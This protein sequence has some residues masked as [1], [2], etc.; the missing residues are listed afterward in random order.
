MTNKDLIALM[1]NPEVQVL[2]T[3]SFIP[4]ELAKLM[5]HFLEELQS[6]DHEATNY[7][8]ALTVQIGFLI[9]FLFASTINMYKELLAFKENPCKILI[10]GLLSKKSSF[11]R[12]NYQA[13]I[14]FL[15]ANFS[16]AEKISTGYS[17]NT[18][19]KGTILY[20][21]LLI[22][23]NTEIYLKEADCWEACELLTALL[24]KIE[25]NSIDQHFNT[26]EQLNDLQNLIINY[27]PKE[28]QLLS[29]NDYDKGLVSIL[30]ISAEIYSKIYFFK[31]PSTEYLFKFID[32][33]FFSCLFPI[34]E[35]P[36]KIMNFKCKSLKSREAAFNLI[37][38][39]AGYNDE[40]NL[41]IMKE[42]IL[43]LS[44]KTDEITT[45][46]FTFDKEERASTGYVG[47]KNLGCICYMNSVLQQLFMVMP[48]RN[49]ILSV[50]DN[51]PPVCNNVFGIDDSTLHQLQLLFGFLLKSN[52]REYNPM[53]FTFSFKERDGKPIN[54]GIQKD[55][56]E[57]LNDLFD[58]LEKSLKDTPY[59]NL[60]QR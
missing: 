34:K 13:L 17:T 33:I 10:Q 25:H 5:L 9:K 36:D 49:A 47:I 15:C 42:L 52:R 12:E 48:F 58:K 27:V 57:F 59:K 41:Y 26:N 51:K 1:S 22:L 16:P 30:K 18:T 39:L 29:N 53:R 44:T 54:T 3:A 50:Q 43:P 32:Y 8:Q 7:L 21:T 31:R 45:W 23:M 24:N 6:P 55:A 28:T 2:L 37:T 20:E 19:Y 14:F 56:T 38:S 46:G 60:V 4:A 11:F 35:S 40:A